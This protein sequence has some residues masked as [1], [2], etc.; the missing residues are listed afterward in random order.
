M[1]SK[2]PPYPSQLFSLPSSHYNTRSTSSSQL[3]LPPNLSSFGHCGDPCHRTSG[4]LE[5]LLG[6]TH[7]ANDI[8]TNDIWLL[9]LACAQYFSD[10]FL[11]ILYYLLIFIELLHD[12]IHQ[13]DFDFGHISY[14]GLKTLKQLCTTG[15]IIL[16]IIWYL[17]MHN[18]NC[19]L[20]IIVRTNVCII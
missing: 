6:F 5:T 17:Y 11:I 9:S 2:S 7:F 14:V 20:Y 10:L 18:I 15:Y 8:S 12:L 4:T 3:N 16:I 1:S 13:L 19:Q